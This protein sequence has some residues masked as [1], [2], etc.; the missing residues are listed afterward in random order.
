LIAGPLAGLAFISILRRGKGWYQ[1]A[2]WASLVVVNLLI[3]FWVVTSSGAWFSVSSLSACSFTPAAPVLTMLV[4]RRAWRRLEA[5][6]GIELPDKRWYT[7]GY[8]LIP[9]LQIVVFVA[10][11]LFGP[12]LCKI[13][14][15]VCQDL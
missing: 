10:L 3:M 6:G 7:L 4:M 9:A 13:G 1:I 5:T 15:V 12:L 11:I 14:L 8:V 2:F